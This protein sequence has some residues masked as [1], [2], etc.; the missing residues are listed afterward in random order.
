[1]GTTTNMT[2]THTAHH[3][4]YFTLQFSCRANRSKCHVS[5]YG[6][7]LRIHFWAI[8]SLVNNFKKYTLAI[9]SCKLYGATCWVSVS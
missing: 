5:K 7:C 1:M 9:P 8:Y 6:S 3:A 4:H 2:C